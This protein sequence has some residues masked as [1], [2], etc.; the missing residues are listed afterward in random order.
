[1]MLLVVMKLFVLRF[2]NDS[3]INKTIKTKPIKI[4]IQKVLTNKI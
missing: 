3:P 1:M 4:E 2:V